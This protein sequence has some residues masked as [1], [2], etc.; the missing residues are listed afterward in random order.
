MDCKGYGC[1][2][3]K[4]SGGFF[5]KVLHLTVFCVHGTVLVNRSP[6][7]VYWE[8]GWQVLV[9]GVN[10][11]Q[12]AWITSTSGSSFAFCPAG[13]RLLKWTGVVENCRNFSPGW[14]EARA[15]ASL[16]EFPTQAAGGGEKKCLN[17]TPS[18]ETNQLFRVNRFCFS[19]CA[20]KLR[21]QIP[22]VPPPPSAPSL[23]RPVWPGSPCGKRA[24]RRH[25][26]GGE[27]F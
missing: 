12:L 23:P 20:F 15:G 26:S 14:G 8:G 10:S 7:R 22:R 18:E 1:L 11:V 13:G 5:V 4:M 27:D 9:S 21:I 19:G 17:P 25:C 24:G 6:T 3:E 16:L 2:T